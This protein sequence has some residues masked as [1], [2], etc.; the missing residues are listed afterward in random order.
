FIPSLFLA[1]SF[2]ICVTAIPGTAR[3]DEITLMAVGDILPHPSWQPF[4]VPA[5]RLFDGVVET[6][7]GADVVLGNL[8]CPLTSQVQ[9]TATK[10]KASLDSKKE[11]VF[12][13]ES[14]DTAQGLRDA[15]F[16]VLALA[17]NHMLDY[18]EA[19]L[20]DTL[21]RLGK[22]GVKTIGGGADRDEAYRPA[23]VDARGLQ[24][25]FLNASD[26]VPKG[27][28]AETDKPGIAIMKDEDAFIKR[29]KTARADYPDAVLVLS[30]HWGVEAT[31]NPTSRQQQLAHRFI[32]AGADAIIGHH[33][34]RIQGVEIYRDRPI[35]YSLGNFQFDTKAPGDRSMIARIMY[36]KGSRTPDK[37]EVMPVLIKEGGYPSVLGQDDK[38]YREIAGMLKELSAPL[39]STLDGVSVVPLAEPSGKGEDYWGT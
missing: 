30:L 7:F 3:A 26:V 17:N 31:S 37:I 22:A 8:E 25:V 18:R 36:A 10:A 34:H 5:A 32:D 2:S 39:G 6:F 20:A 23:V 11:F 24:M 9:P 38:V 1:L 29:I 21:S 19:G 16:T 27:Y 14:E 28:W 12:K 33:P 15:G 4:E 13:A 35:F